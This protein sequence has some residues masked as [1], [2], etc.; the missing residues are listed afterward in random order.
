VN[1][2]N[3]F[4]PCVK[5][6]SIIVRGTAE[7]DAKRAFARCHAEEGYC[8]AN[9]TTYFEIGSS[10]DECVVADDD[11]GIRCE[12]GEELM[13]GMMFIRNTFETSIAIDM[14]CTCIF[15]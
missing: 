13:P 15:S 14:Q 9:H 6:D 5:D 8:K 7:T 1:E 3:C 10:E 4:S 12:K 11:L 2:V